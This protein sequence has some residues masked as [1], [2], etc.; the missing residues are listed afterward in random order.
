MPKLNNA[1]AVQLHWVLVLADVMRCIK[2]A[3]RVPQLVVPV[4]RLR[5]V[6]LNEW[7][8]TAL[9]RVTRHAEVV[10]WNENFVLVPVTD[11]VEDTI[12]SDDAPMR[13]IITVK[14]SDAGLEGHV[15]DAANNN[16]SFAL[17]T[18]IDALDREI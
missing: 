7:L 12:G 5:S 6:E 10:R 4:T 11:V 17:A 8:L 15:E 14:H 16:G 18:L 9:D 3:H 1:L 2:R 13:V